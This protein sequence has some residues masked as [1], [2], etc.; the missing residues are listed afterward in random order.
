MN[1]AA[2]SEPRPGSR[3]GSLVQNAIA[4]MVSSGGTAILGLGFWGI[5][6]RLASA[7]TV[8][9]ASAEIAAM[10]LLANLAQLS[11]TTIFDRFLPV[12]GDRTRQFVRNAYAVC[13][14]VALAVGAI[15]VVAGFGS[16]T[17]P[18]PFGWRAL[19][20]V[21]VVLWTIFIIQDSVLTGLR[22]AKWV[23][24]E[25]ILFAAAKIALLPIFL[26]YLPRQGI[27][28]AWVVPAIA[29]TAITGM[30]STTDPHAEI[31]VDNSMVDQKTQ[32]T[33]SALFA[34]S[35]RSVLHFTKGGGAERSFRLV[36]ETYCGWLQQK[37]AN[38]QADPAA[39]DRYNNEEAAA[40]LKAA[41]Q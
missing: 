37:V 17:V 7:K 10:V 6:A 19:F 18:V 4:L 15:Y 27:F 21:A 40:M 14:A 20:V 22:A 9:R 29:V 26:H 33:T 3:L 41:R 36:Q 25:N 35:E 8:G 13:M 31:V 2:A 16:R 30:A 11:F 12:T 38:F 39:A 28:L 32:T 23:P 24:V 1:D 5:A 34:G